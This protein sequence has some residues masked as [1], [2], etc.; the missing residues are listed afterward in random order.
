MVFKACLVDAR[1]DNPTIIRLLLP[2]N[3][4][5]ALQ[6]GMFRKLLRAQGPAG[7]MSSDDAISEAVKKEKKPLRKIHVQPSKTKARIQGINRRIR[8]NM[9]LV[10]KRF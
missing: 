7:Q 5:E 9:A 10:S 1:E 8:K 4:S 3:P 6:D 2:V